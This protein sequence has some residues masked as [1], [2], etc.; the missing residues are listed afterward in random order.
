VIHAV[1]RDTGE[2]EMSMST[3]AMVKYRN[4]ADCNT[5]KITKKITPVI[6]TVI[7]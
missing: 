6:Y 7:L 2:H 1:L 4:M 3:E 5:G